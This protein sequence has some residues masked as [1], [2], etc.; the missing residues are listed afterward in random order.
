MQQRSG[1][2]ITAKL[3]A[4][5]T[6]EKLILGGGLL[7]VIA[8]FL[9]WIKISVS[10]AAGFGGASA[11][12]SA[13]G[14]PAPIWGILALLVA[15][16]LAG[17]VI[18]RIMDMQLPALPPQYSWGQVFAAGGG[19]LIV[20]T[21]LKAWRIQAV[22]VGGGLSGIDKSFGFGFF[23]GIICALAVGAGGY[24]MYTAEKG[25][26]QFGGGYRR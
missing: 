11:S 18:A 5:S 19:A 20:L 17:I 8:S 26:S 6:G 13:L 4:L 15:I 22:D 10:G 25:G 1:N 16:V 3:S 21:L 9:P 7:F 24:M 2:D 23:I 14:D 12:E